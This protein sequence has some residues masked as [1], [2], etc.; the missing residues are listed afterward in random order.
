MLFPCN[1]FGRQEPGNDQA[2]LQKYEGRGVKW[3][4]LEKGNVAY[5][6]KQDQVQ[7]LYEWLL[8]K[9][10]DAGAHLNW[11]FGKFLIDGT[12]KPHRF[13][14]PSFQPLTLEK[15]IETLLGKLEPDHEEL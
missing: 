11:N 9:M 8:K 10:P 4:L 6:H 15:E 14:A 5:L 1:Q 12:G 7:P 13:F 2:V 3:T